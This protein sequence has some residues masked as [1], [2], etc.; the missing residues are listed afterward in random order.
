MGQESGRRRIQRPPAPRV[1]ASVRGPS[2]AFPAAQP[3]LSQTSVSQSGGFSPPV[4]APLGPNHL[5]TAAAVAVAVAAAPGLHL[6]RTSIRA[7]PGGGD[8][9][10]RARGS[11]GSGGRGEPRRRTSLGGRQG[12]APLHDGPAEPGTGD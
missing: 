5:P 1:S 12:S 11:G 3:R 9:L 2:L 4:P 6:H 10:P 7:R 8:R